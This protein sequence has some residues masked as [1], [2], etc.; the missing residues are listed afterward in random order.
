MEI[1][2]YDGSY[3]DLGAPYVQLGRFD[4]ATA[5]LEKALERDWYDVQAHIELGNLHLQPAGPRARPGTRLPCSCTTGPVTTDDQ[6][7]CDGGP[8]ADSSHH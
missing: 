5:L 4:E 3:V 8:G 7:E 2:E 6:E 1:D